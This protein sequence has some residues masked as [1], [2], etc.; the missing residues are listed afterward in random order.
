[1]GQMFERPSVAMDERL[2]KLETRMRACENK[3][4]KVEDIEQVQQIQMNQIREMQNVQSVL[5]ADRSRQDDNM[6]ILAKR[7]A[8]NPSTLFTPRKH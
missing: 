6:D 3:C 4:E 1:M 2:R 5:L 7:V 8:L